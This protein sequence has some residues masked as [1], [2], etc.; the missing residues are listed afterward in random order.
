MHLD[1]PLTF[2]LG[3]GSVPGV[4]TTSLI[5]GL[6]VRSAVLLKPGLGDIPLPLFFARGL[7]EEDPELARSL[8]VAVLAGKGEWTDRDG[9]ERGGPGGDL[10]E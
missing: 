7:E 1:S 4:A 9:L 3:A 6:L 10:R 2:H 8:A 5:R